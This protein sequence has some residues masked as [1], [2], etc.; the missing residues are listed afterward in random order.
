MRAK[1]GEASHFHPHSYLARR[2]LRYGLDLA[3]PALPED[4]FITL[5][6][7]LLISA[8]GLAGHLMRGVA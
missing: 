4:P 5:P 3:D 6:G 2:V 7:W 1:C 8:S